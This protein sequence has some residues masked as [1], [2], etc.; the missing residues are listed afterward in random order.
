[1]RHSANSEYKD[2][3]TFQNKIRSEALWVRRLCGLFFLY[4]AK[5]LVSSFGTIRLLYKAAGRTLSLGP[6][7]VSGFL[8]VLLIHLMLSIPFSD[9]KQIGG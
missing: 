3:V 8:H 6:P 2:A 1:L 9:R 7:D 5:V 4:P